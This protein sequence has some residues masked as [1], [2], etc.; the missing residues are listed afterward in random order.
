MDIRRATAL[1]IL[2][3]RRPRRALDLL[4]GGVPT[5]NRRATTVLLDLSDASLA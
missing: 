5:P 4:N 3:A 2:S 1:G